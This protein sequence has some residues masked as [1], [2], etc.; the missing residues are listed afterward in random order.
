LNDLAMIRF[1]V[2]A[3]H[4][5]QMD[6]SGMNGGPSAQDGKVAAKSGVLLRASRLRWCCTRNATQAWIIVSRE[7]ELEMPSR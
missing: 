7:G 5:K 4:R 6:G 3:G 2:P 1:S